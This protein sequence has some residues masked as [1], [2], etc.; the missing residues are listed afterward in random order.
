V[1]LYAEEP[2]ADV[3]R[4]LASIVVSSLA[5]VEVVAALWRKHRVGELTAEDASLLVAEFEWDWSDEEALFVRLKLTDEIIEEAA[6]CCA[7]HPL[8]AADAI[9]LASALVARTADPELASFACF[10]DRLR[11]AAAAE[12]FTLSA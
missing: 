4:T 8:R 5:R 6:R 12:G 7:R 9:Q 3:V 1:K 2:G 11:A 10:D